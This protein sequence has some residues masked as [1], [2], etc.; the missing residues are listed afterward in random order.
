MPA[1]PA[2]IRT[3]GEEKVIEFKEPR[4]KSG[5]SLKE[6]RRLGKI[7]KPANYVRASRMK[8]NF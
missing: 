7:H 3:T 2:P 1:T 6:L 5:P 4:P 8:M